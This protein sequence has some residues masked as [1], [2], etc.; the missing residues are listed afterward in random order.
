MA[1]L[2]GQAHTF[3]DIC[4]HRGSALSLGRID[5]CRLAPV[6]RRRSRCFTFVGHNYALDRDQESH[7]MQ[8]VILGG[9]TTARRGPSWSLSGPRNCRLT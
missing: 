1:R 3:S 4:R 5:G 7:D 9:R 2:D 6:N 8:Y